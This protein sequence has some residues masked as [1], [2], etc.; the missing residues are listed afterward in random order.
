MTLSFFYYP[1]VGDGEMMY[2]INV[3]KG[4]DKYDYR[5]YY[6]CFC[7]MYNHTIAI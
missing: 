6:W 3:T 7:R 5:I 4:G 2:F 1:Y